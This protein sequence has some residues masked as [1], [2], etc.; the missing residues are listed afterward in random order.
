MTGLFFLCVYFSLTSMSAI[1]V[2]VE[3]RGIHHV[4]QAAGS[5]HSRFLFHHALPALGFYSPSASFLTSLLSD[6]IMLRFFPAL[7]FGII[8]CERAII[9]LAR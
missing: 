2:F 7:L 3:E 8:L 1:S 6:V 4:E 9:A 5:L